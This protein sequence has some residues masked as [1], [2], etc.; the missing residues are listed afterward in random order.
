[1]QQL[2]FRALEV[3]VV[4]GERGGVAGAGRELGITSA[5]AS[6]AISRLE[7]RLGTALFE[8]GSRRVHLTD[9]GAKLLRLIR[10][11]VYRMQRIIRMLDIR[12]VPRGA[13]R[14]P[15][16]G[17]EPAL[18]PARGIRRNARSAAISPHR[19]APDNSATCRPLRARAKA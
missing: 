13:A 11:D 5:A 15:L 19:D 4:A 9:Q 7:D 17:T 2:G 1:M 8:A 16:C 10:A 3:F 6:L 18:K 12:E 14:L